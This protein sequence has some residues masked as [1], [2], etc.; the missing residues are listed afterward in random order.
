[1][2]APALLDPAGVVAKRHW[3]AK[4]AAGLLARLGLGQVAEVHRRAGYDLERLEGSLTTSGHLR[5]QV[6]WA[7][8]LAQGRTLERRE[9]WRR[10]DLDLSIEEFIAWSEL[11]AGRR[12]LEA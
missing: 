5:V 4:E 12:R 7:K 10:Y 11:L 9:S 6:R 8:L 3:R 2:T 1:M